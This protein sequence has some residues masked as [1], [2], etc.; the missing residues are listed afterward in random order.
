L[1]VPDILAKIWLS[2]PV[3]YLAFAIMET[4]TLELLASESRQAACHAAEEAKQMDLSNDGYRA[5]FVSVV[6]PVEQ[7][8]ETAFRVAC[9]LAKNSPDME[10]TAQIWERMVGICDGVLEYLREFATVLPGETR[11][12]WYDNILDWRN[13]AQ[14][15]FELHS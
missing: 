5:K 4:T 2:H 3:R 9:V 14:E 10:E 7:L 6:T 12:D 11:M 1:F 8:T 13:A 15:R